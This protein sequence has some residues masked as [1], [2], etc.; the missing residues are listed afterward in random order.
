MHLKLCWHV[1]TCAMVT[2]LVYLT[3]ACKSQTGQTH[4][5]PSSEAAPN[6]VRPEILDFADEIEHGLILHP[7]TE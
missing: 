5:V 2:A 7:I 3:C 4:L 6:K 1:L